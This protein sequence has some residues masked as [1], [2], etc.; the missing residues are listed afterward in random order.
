MFA[1]YHPNPHWLPYYKWFWFVEN[2]FT[3]TKTLPQEVAKYILE[4][5]QWRK[6]KERKILDKEF[7][8]QKGEKDALQNLENRGK[9]IGEN[10]F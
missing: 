5:Y 3:R 7:A 2:L 9:T 8:K 6:P 1:R 10:S 4:F